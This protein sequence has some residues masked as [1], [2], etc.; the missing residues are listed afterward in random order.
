MNGRM[1]KKVR[2]EINRVNKQHIR[3]FMD[4]VVGM[5]WRERLVLCWHIM[6]LNKEGTC[7]KK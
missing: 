6:K 5:T 1:A 4:M 2:K 7:L 3:N